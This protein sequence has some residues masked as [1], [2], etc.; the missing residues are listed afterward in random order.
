MEPWEISN[1]LKRR[2][3]TPDRIRSW[4]MDPLTNLYVGQKVSIAAQLMAPGAGDWIDREEIDLNVYL[5]GNGAIAKPYLHIVSLRKT[6]SSKLMRFKVELEQ[7]GDLN[8]CFRVF[9]NEPRVPCRP[10]CS[11]PLSFRLRVLPAK[12]PDAGV[13]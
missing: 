4:V 11:C 7:A 1:T 6:V 3:D 9:W 5:S 12:S 8:M 13:W 2:L 10:I